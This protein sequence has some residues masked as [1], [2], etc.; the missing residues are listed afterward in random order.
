MHLTKDIG[1]SAVA[2]SA[3]W[4][5]TGYIQ[6]VWTTPNGEIPTY[7]LPFD[8]GWIC[9]WIL[10]PAALW[11]S[12]FCL[13]I[14][15]EDHG[16]VPSATGLEDLLVRLVDIDVGPLASNRPVLKLKV[17]SFHSL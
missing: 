6:S 9:A 1:Y 10:S 11:T 2:E 8:L 3:G 4:I 12:T 14:P 15:W 5:P 16:H 13:T 7:N 17:L